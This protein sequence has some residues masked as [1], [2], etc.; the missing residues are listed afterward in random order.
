MNV[1]SNAAQAIDGSGDIFIR[2]KKQGLKAVVE[3]Q[4]SGKGMPPEIIDK[5]FDPFFTTKSIGNGTGLGLSI[6]YSIVQKHDGEIQVE[7]KPNKGTTFKIILP[8]AG[9]ATTT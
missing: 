5:I 7:S 3:I 4:D 6:S 2:L 9:P 1:L 8:I